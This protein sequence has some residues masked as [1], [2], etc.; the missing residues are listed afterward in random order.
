MSMLMLGWTSL[1]WCDGPGHMD[2]SIATQKAANEA[3]RPEWPGPGPLGRDRSASSQAQ[4]R[5]IEADEGS[6]VVAPRARPTVQSALMIFAR[7]AR[8]LP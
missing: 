2:R 5:H 3:E 8:A 4:P 1:A 6:Q 7:A